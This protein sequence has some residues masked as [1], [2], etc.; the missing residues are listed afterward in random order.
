MADSGNGRVLRFP[1]PF[2]SYQPG[3]PQQADLVLG[4]LSFNSTVPDATQRT[5]EL[6]YGLAFTASTGLMVSDF[7]QSRVLFFPGDQ[8]NPSS[9]SSGEAATLVFGQ[10]NF[11]FDNSGL[12]S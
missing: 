6:P 8:H 5:M 10:P 1:T 9:F 4:Q 11:T 7:A 12:G 3:T 2:A